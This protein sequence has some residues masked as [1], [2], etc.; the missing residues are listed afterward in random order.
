MFTYSILDG[1]GCII[2]LYKFSNII[3]IGG[4]CKHVLIDEYAIYN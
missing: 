3:N 2:E 4:M 1:M